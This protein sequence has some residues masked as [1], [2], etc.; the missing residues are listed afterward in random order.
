MTLDG[1]NLTV[2]C[3]CPGTPHGED[4]VTFKAVLPL[5]AGIAAMAALRD[6]VEKYGTDLNALVLGETLYPIYFAHAIESWTFTKEDGSPLLQA[7]ADAVLP[8]DVKFAI[9]DAADDIFGE[10]VARPLVAMIQRL[11][12]AGQTGRLTSPKRDSGSSPRS[13]S[14]RSSPAV[15][16][17]SEP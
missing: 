5:A 10:Q 2:E 15:S 11:L 6:S 8:F 16:A 3:P 12:P 4:M 17:V 9:A 13:R 1:R 7:E 14:R